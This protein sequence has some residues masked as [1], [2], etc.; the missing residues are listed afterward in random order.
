ML[1][2]IS[3]A[4]GVGGAALVE[5]PAD[6]GEVGAPG[7]ALIAA[8]ADGGEVGGAA[9]AAAPAAPEVVAR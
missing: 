2:E 3:K 1:F 9:L 7:A 6:G 5:A 4:G 8:P